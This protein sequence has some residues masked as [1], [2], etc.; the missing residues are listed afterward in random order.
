M[1][2]IP[3][4]R[5]GSRHARYRLKNQYANRMRLLQ[6]PV[7]ETGYYHSRTLLGPVRETQQIISKASIFLRGAS[8]I[9]VLDNA[10]PETNR[11]AC[12][13]GIC[14]NAI[15]SNK[16]TITRRGKKTPGSCSPEAET[17]TG[18]GAGA[19]RGEVYHPLQYR[20]LIKARHQQCHLFS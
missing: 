7:C 10:P 19:L 1:R 20:H 11:A 12:V 5:T 9:S 16:I 4:S 13:V 6:G 2:E 8:K 17:E 14:S 15:D 3:A 18:V